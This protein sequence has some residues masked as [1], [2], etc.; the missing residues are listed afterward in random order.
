MKKA[1]SV[2]AKMKR[3][4]RRVA[5][6]VLLASLGALTLWTITS[7]V[8]PPTGGSSSLTH[9]SSSNHRDALRAA[10]MSRGQ[11]GRSASGAGDA[12]GEDGRRQVASS[13]AW[14]PVV[15]DAGQARAEEG[16]EQDLE[17]SQGDGDVNG[18]AGGGGVDR[19]GRHGRMIGG[20]CKCTAF[21]AGPECRRVI[22]LPP[23]LRSFPM[24]NFSGAMEGDIVI[25]K[26]TVRRDGQV[27]VH[28]PG[29]ENDPDK[30]YRVLIA[31]DDPILKEFINVLPE[32][33]PVVG[34]FYETCAV[35]GSSGIVLNYEHGPDIDR[36]DMVFRFNSAP[37]KGFEKH[38]GS[39]TTYRI[40]NTQNWGFHEAHTDETLLIHFRAKSAVKGLF[41]NAKQKKPFKLYA[42]AP[43]LVH[44]VAHG[45]EFM[46]TSGLYGIL[47]ALSRCNKV[48]VYGFQ[49]ST[50][51]GTLYHYYD[52]CDVPANVERDDTEWVVVR[53]L[54][55][56]GLITFAE[57]CIP[58]CHEGKAKCDAC[59]AASGFN[60]V[61]YGSRAKCDPNA[62]SRGHVELPWR[63]E[64]K[65]ARAHGVHHG[66]H[67]RR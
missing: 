36:H 56:A 66:G 6:G 44:Y 30:G 17:R 33:D 42:F 1:A 10:V 49:V 25:N 7:V 39:K 48:D 8:S 60:E 54:A 53:E 55:R 23:A 4:K 24:S 58:E 2:P 22:D 5:Q 14:E 18:S 47:L 15:R 57:P 67:G 43:D 64:R 37:T 20:A 40:T 41:W 34:A 59:K 61:K 52:V 27:A 12:K 31:P 32:H 35:V 26:A 11:A 13:S 63:A 3:F 29:K 19:C 38:V 62:V 50:A 28:L 16:E 65:A 9:Q 21:Y 45:L 46:A 51:H